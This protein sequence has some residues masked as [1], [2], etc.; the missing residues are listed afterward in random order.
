VPNGRTEVGYWALPD[1]VARY[2][3]KVRQS[4]TTELTADEIHEIGL[5]EVTRIEAEQAE[6]GKQLGFADFGK[7]KQHIRGN[8]KLYAKNREEILQRYRKYVE[9]MYTKLPQLFGR[10]PQQH[11]R[12]EAVE[13]FR[14][15]EASARSTTRAPRTARA[16]ASCRSIPTSRPSA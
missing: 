9:Q 7:F 3:A 1:G 15:K 11:M 5:K 8:K 4:T 13:Q 14:E 16:P 6:I 12:V 10:L 2:N